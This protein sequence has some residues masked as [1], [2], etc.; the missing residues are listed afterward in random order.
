[1][2]PLLSA[3]AQR[4]LA[5]ARQHFPAA[6]A[7]L[8]AVLPRLLHPLLTD[9]TDP[10]R[11]GASLLTDGGYPLEF[12]CTTRND[13]IRYTLEVAPARAQ[14][15]RRLAQALA[16][17]EPLLMRSLA[18]EPALA[19]L[20]QVQASGGLRYGAWLGVRHAA[21][22]TAYKL[23]AEVPPG[24]RALAVA[25]LNA[26]LRRPVGVPGRAIVPQMIGWYPA[27]GELEFYFRVEGLRPWELP[28]LMHPLGLETSYA[29]V[30]NA[31][32]RAHGRPMHQQ[33]PG[34]VFGCSYT[35]AAAPTADAQPDASRLFSF[36]TFAETLFG[37]DAYAY[38]KLGR[39]FE[40]GGHAMAYYHALSAPTA[41]HQAPWMHHGMFG[42][43]VGPGTPAV[44]HV[45]LRPPSPAPDHD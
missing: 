32:E 8:D 13:S 2:V 7:Q 3:P 25:Y 9:P 11:W 10:A 21:H 6:A 34:P 1:M 30:F 14:P 20:T 43:T 39:Y 19:L 42:V 4:G 36:Y 18:Q 45:G 33:L 31:F 27:T 35:V 24:G 41:T 22:D 28:A 23:Y 5:L 29:T 12:T 26:R 37:P 15:A 16:L 44:V 38:R 40:Q 17:V